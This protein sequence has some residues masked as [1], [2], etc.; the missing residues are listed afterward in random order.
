MALFAVNTGCRD[1]EICTLRWEWEV[2][3]L[4]IDAFVLISCNTQVRNGEARLVVLNRIARSVVDAQRRRHQTH[5]FTY[6]GAAQLSDI[7]LFLEEGATTGK[8]AAGTGSRSQ[9]HLWPAFAS[10]WGNV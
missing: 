7:N 10:C 9:A 4:E 8:L 2:K 1:R 6:K 5:V 3:V